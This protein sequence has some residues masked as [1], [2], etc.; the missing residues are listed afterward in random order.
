MKFESLLKYICYKVFLDNEIYNGVLILNKIL[1]GE[2]FKNFL[3]LIF[4]I[5]S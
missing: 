5:V 2:L 1:Y 3:M 4:F